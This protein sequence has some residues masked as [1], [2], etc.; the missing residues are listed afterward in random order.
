MI[1]TRTFPDVFLSGVAHRRERRLEYYFPNVVYIYI[2]MFVCFCV[3]ILR[4]HSK[5]EQGTTTYSLR[6]AMYAWSNNNIGSYTGTYIAYMLTS[7]PNHIFLDGNVGP[8]HI[9]T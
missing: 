8:E 2:Y 3:T 5:W 6:D 9:L 4:I 1:Y 7:A